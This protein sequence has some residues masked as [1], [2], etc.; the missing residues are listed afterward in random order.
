MNIRLKFN[1]VLLL[2]FS[3]GLLISAY[4]SKQVLQDN[5][6]Q[7]VVRN[8]ELMMETALAIRSYTV[9]QVKP[10]L[11]VALQ[12]KFL[13]QSVPAY[14]ATETILMLR[15][16]YPGYTYKEATLNPTNPRDRAADWEG[17]VIREF[18]SDPEREQI[19]GERDGKNGRQL[20]IARPITIKSAPCLVCHSTPEA[21]PASMIKLYGKDNGFGWQLGETVGAQIVTI[22][23]QIPF[24]Q[25]SQAFRLFMVSL[26]IVFVLLFLA[27]NLMISV[28]VIRPITRMAEAAEEAT[29]MKSNFLANM[30]HEIRT[31]MNAVIGL[32][33]LALQTGLTPKQR[34]Y[35]AKIQRAGQSLLGVINDILD[36]SK[37]EAGRLDIETVPFALDEVLASV[38]TVTSQKAADKQIEYLFHVPPDVPRHLQGDPL[39]LGQ[40]LVN[41]INNAIKFTDAGGEIQLAITVSDTSDDKVTLYFA[42][43]D[44]GIGMSREQLTRLFLPFTQA[45]GS[46]TR[47]YG[48]T[49]LGLS[50]SRK[51]VQLMGG[52]IAVRS[53][54]RVGSV[55]HF[56]LPFTLYAHDGKE[57]VLPS[58][59]NGARVLVVDDNAPARMVLAE[60]LSALPV[61]VES[62]DS[63][64]AAMAAIRANDALSPYQIVLTDW[65]MPH[66]DGVALIRAVK[67]DSSLANKPRLVLVT[68]FGRDEVQHSAEEAGADGLLFKPVGPSALVDMLV[69]VFSEGDK[70]N[71]PYEHAAHGPKRDYS[72]ARVLL[73]EDN[74]VNQQIAIELLSIV[75]I[76]CDVAE[77]GR[78][79]VEMALSAPLDRYAM[80]LM[81]LQ[82]P[83]MDGHEACIAIRQDKRLNHIPIVAL[84][85]HAVGDIR[86]RCLAE[87]M[88]DFLTKPIYPEKLFELL[89]R[90]LKERRVV[91][92]APPLSGQTV[93]A[94][95]STEDARFAA[96]TELDTVQGLAFMAGNHDLYLKLL[97]R[98][99]VHQATTAEKL[100]ALLADQQYHEAERLAHTLKGLS[101]SLGAGRLA[102][103][104]A[105]LEAALAEHRQHLADS[106]DGDV[107][108]SHLAVLKIQLVTTL[109]VVLSQLNASLPRPDAPA[110]AAALTPVSSVLEM[111]RAAEL[112]GEPDLTALRQLIELLRM[113]DGETLAYFDAEMAALGKVLDAQTLVQL[114]EQISGFAFSEAEAMLLA[115]WPEA[116]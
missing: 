57:A 105:T 48:G 53:T 92:A 11:E 7:A 17:D 33:H 44:N 99:R 60:A 32:A 102:D 79:A 72:G 35:V 106:V 5:A 115:I 39:R 49:G 20:Y 37:I 91:D 42:V 14:A 3:V 69:K 23:T 96:L 40:V 82:M 76:A 108:A 84:T 111:P 18:R 36:F 13:P 54:P 88:Q 47:Q 112:Q 93:A 85:A 116:A 100:D 51:L 31:P 94:A 114:R 45:D 71:V 34:D 74:A 27:L 21:A 70:A 52:E 10:N 8:A 26:I 12:Q 63:A 25:A 1:L 43:R 77:H 46:T 80:I 29:R 19:V 50:I 4:L 68:A 78:E 28:F 30:S 9:N 83:F 58:S 107:D 15:Q 90:W 6:Q 41:L 81:D 113:S 67:A 64:H 66:M 95:F 87:G 2:C 104:A 38:A 22:P 59:I 86:E 101:A 109:Q 65:Q 73:V 75:G 89:D 24:Q 61:K 55:F 62:V 110:P 97:E 16:K 98:F 103:L 56:E